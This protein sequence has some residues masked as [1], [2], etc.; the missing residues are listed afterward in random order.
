MRAAQAHTEHY[1][2][3][4]VGV[5]SAAPATPVNQEIARDA[6]DAIGNSI[7]RMRRHLARMRTHARTIGDDK[8]LA[9]LDDVERQLTVAKQHHEAL[10]A[11][12]A[13]DTIDPATA[14]RHVEQV[15]A[16]LEKARVEHDEVMQRLGDRDDP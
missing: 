14:L 4:L 1:R 6:G 10:H 7:D 12:H 3:Y 9:M 15:N 11:H 5:Q 8:S 13:A 16:A 2:D